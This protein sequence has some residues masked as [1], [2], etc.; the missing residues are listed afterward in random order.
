M[1][2]DF[3]NLGP[4]AKTVGKLLLPGIKLDRLSSPL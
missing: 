2:M 3:E 4:R 1:K